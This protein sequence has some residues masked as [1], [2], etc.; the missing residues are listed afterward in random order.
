MRISLALLLFIVIGQPVFAQDTGLEMLNIAPTPFSLSKGEATTSV[1]DG[2]ASMF[3]NPALLVMNPTS[4]LNLGYSIW[5]AD[6]DNVFGGVNF[7]SNRRAAAFS[8][9]SSGSSNYQQRNQPGPSNGDFSIQYLSVSAA[10]AYDFSLFSLGA[11]AQYLNEQAY[12]YR[13]SGYAFNFGIARN[14]LDERIR[15]GVSFSNLGEMGKLNN[16]ATELPSNFKMG[17]S[18]DI[19]QFSPPKN[20]DLPIL[21]SVAVDYVNPLQSTDNKDY[22]N[23][24][25][26]D[27][28]LNLGFE[29]TVAE[30][31]SVS[32][33]YKTQNSVRPISFGASIHSE[34][35]T[36]DYALIPF[37]TGFGTVHSIGIK[38]KF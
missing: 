5:I 6:V 28:H 18:A 22:A 13:A 1:P 7:K 36:F 34:T 35:I 14:F 29:F 33:G 2:A 9:Y 30:V 15:T 21:F 8:F 24:T 25:S 12:S 27:P 20:N 11:T 4:S 26:P 31:L 3:S 38:Y 23:Y 16:E 32:T 10:Y 19:V 17:I 37:N